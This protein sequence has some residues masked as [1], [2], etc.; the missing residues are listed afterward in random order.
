MPS[1]PLMTSFEPTGVERGPEPEGRHG[2]VVML[3]RRGVGLSDGL[4]Y[5]P[6]LEQ[7]ADDL[8]AVMDAEGLKAP[9][10]LAVATASAAAALLAAQSPARVRSLTIFMSGF[11]FNNHSGISEEER[12]AVRELFDEW[13]ANW[14]TGPWPPLG[15][16]AGHGGQPARHGLGRALGDDARGGA[17]LAGLILRPPDRRCPAGHPA[18]SPVNPWATRHACRVARGCPIGSRATTGDRSR[19]WCRRGGRVEREAPRA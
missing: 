17:R 6:T 19:T 3:Q 16:G 13:V 4:D 1:R 9:G 14:A 2:R 10:I 5:V 12:V 15:P 7:Q 8:L 11:G 18:R